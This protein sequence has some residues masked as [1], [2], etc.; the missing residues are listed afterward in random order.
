MT[1]LTIK[2]SVVMCIVCV[3]V[4]GFCKCV[5]AMIAIQD[6]GELPCKQDCIQ[7]LIV[8]K[9]FVRSNGAKRA[10]GG[11]GASP[12]LSPRLIFLFVKI[13][14][15]NGREGGGVNEVVI[16]KIIFVYNSLNWI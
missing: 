2:L 3:S 5:R 4:M 6:G 16:C 15:E 11:G 10:I 8:F 1:F 9:Y 12:Q 14:T 13:R 7:F